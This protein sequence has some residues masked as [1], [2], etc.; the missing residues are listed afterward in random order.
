M[1]LF[2]YQ[3]EGR[4]KFLKTDRLRRVDSFKSWNK[5]GEERVDKGFKGKSPQITHFVEIFQNE[6]ILRKVVGLEED[7]KIQNDK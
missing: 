6:K 7:I 5:Q 1:S 3:S 2:K 4:R